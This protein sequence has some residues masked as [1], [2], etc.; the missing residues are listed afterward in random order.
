MKKIFLYAIVLFLILTVGYFGSIYYGLMRSPVGP[1]DSFIKSN[2]C[3]IQKN[4][5]D[6]ELNEVFIAKCV[7]QTYFIANSEEDLTKYI[8]IKVNI[9]AIYPANKSNTDSVQTSEQ[10]I[11]KKC[12][13]IFKDN[14]S[15]YAIVIQ[16]IEKL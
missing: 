10:C 2:E 14:R 4:K 1:P 13:S 15:V 3:I 7:T 8:D 16:K 5:N 11:A 9:Q 6:D 12:Q